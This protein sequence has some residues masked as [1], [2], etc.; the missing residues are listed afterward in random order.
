MTIESQFFLPESV[1]E[2]I[3]AK[4]DKSSS[5]INSLI[6]ENKLL[7]QKVQLAALAN[8]LNEGLGIGESEAITLG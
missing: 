8:R 3:S 4:Q 7:I 6:S 1:I 5:H 2:G